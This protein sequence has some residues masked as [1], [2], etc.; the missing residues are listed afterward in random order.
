MRYQK[1]IFFANNSPQGKKSD[2][3][4]LSFLNISIAE[5]G[6]PLS[7]GVDETYQ[8]SITSN[9]EATLKANTDWGALRGLDTFSQLV[10][11]D[12]PSGNYFIQ[13][14]PISI[15][16]SPRFQWRGLLIDSARHYLDIPSIMRQ[17][18]MFFLFI[19]IN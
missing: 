16:D 13:H 15:A 7:I 14:A 17:L 11:I 5:Q 3:A 19:L 8:L 6:V 10:N 1:Y 9:G 4:T 2:V 18:G 12:I